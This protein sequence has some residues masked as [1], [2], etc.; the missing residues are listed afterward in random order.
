MYRSV[1]RETS[2]PMADRVFKIYQ[3]RAEPFDQVLPG[4]H[5][6]FYAIKA[7]A[8]DV[9]GLSEQP[10]DALVERARSQTNVPLHDLVSELDLRVLDET[11][12]RQLERA[13][14]TLNI[15]LG[16][17]TDSRFPRTSLGRQFDAA[18]AALGLRGDRNPRAHAQ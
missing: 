16:S 15:P 10:I 13:V 18:H 3:E 1:R 4:E 14:I 11:Q 7:Y 12:L 2:E 17:H 5:M 8:P 6:P 9:P